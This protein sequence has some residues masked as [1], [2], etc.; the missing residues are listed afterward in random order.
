MHSAEPW[1]P[2]LFRAGFSFLSHLLLMLMLTISQN[3]ITK[4]ERRT[5]VFQVLNIMSGI[6]AL[7]NVQNQINLRENKIVLSRNSADLPGSDRGN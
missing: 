2:E 3:K 6:W 5:K 4:Q 7:G 1:C